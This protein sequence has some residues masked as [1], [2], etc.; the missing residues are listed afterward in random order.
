M[1]CK[2]AIRIGL[3]RIFVLELRANQAGLVCPNIVIAHEVAQNRSLL[4]ILHLPKCLRC[5]PCVME[6]ESRR[7]C[8]YLACDLPSS[9]SAGY[10]SQ[11]ES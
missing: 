3:R 7:L 6:L 4:F 9:F 10:S 1:Y 8:D 11:L 5:I 2:C